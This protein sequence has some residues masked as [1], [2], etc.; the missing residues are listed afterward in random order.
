VDGPEFDAHEVDF[1]LLMKRNN[2]YR[3]EE[4]SALDKHVCNIDK[5]FAEAI[6]N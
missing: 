1:T 2:T 3:S 4:K 6:N 5:Q